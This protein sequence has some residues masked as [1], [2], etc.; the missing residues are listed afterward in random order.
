DLARTLGGQLAEL[1]VADDDRPVPV[2]V[3]LV[4]LAPLDDL[5]AHLA[6]ALVADASAVLV[7]HLVEAEVVA[8]GGAV[9][10]DRHVDQPEGDRALPDRAHAHSSRAR[11]TVT[12]DQ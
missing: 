5:A 1:L 10:G 6:A 9:D 7:V 2:V 8:L 3:G 4:D 11:S 12:G